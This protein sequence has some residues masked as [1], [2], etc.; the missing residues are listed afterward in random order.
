MSNWKFIFPQNLL[1]SAAPLP[2]YKTAAVKK[3]KFILSHYGVFK[4]CWDWFVLVATLY[5]A[6]VVP[7]NAAFIDDDDTLCSDVFPI[8][9]RSTDCN[10]TWPAESGFDSEKEGGEGEEEAHVAIMEEREG[11]IGL[12][13]NAS[14]NASCDHHSSLGADQPDRPSL[15]TDVVVEILFIVG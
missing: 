8:E 14:R 9:N 7:Y 1:H 11:R 3:S 6:V 2:E 15:V 12:P 13:C 10:E 5:V 4:T